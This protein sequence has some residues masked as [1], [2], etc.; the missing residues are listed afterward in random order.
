MARV[1]DVLSRKARSLHTVE[2]GASVLE[3]ARV[4]NDH[5]IGSVVVVHGGRMVGILTERDILTRVVA[6]QVLTCRPDTTLNEARLVMRERRIRHLPVLEGDRVVG[7]LSLG[8]LNNAEHDTL[9]ETIQ[10]ME[11]YIAGGSSTLVPV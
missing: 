2:S 8:D 10:I 7:M 5:K 4:M 9:V 3:A 11:A 1:R 6:R